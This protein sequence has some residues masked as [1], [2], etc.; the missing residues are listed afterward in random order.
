MEQPFSKFTCFKRLAPELRLKIWEDA[1]PEP[2]IIDLQLLNEHGEQLSDLRSSGWQWCYT[3]RKNNLEALSQ[4]NHEA[5]DVYLKSYQKTDILEQLG[6]FSRK[7]YIDFSRDIFYPNSRLYRSSSRALDSEVARGFLAR[8]NSA[9]TYK[10]TLLAVHPSTL[11]KIFDYGHLMGSMGLMAARGRAT[12]FLLHTFL[13]FPKLQHLRVVIDGRN[14]V[15]SG[16]HEIVEPSEANEDYVYFGC[17]AVIQAGFADFLKHLKEQN[18]EISI[19]KT[20]LALIINGKDTAKW[21]RRWDY[22]YMSCLCSRKKIE[23]V[24][25]VKKAKEVKEFRKVKEVKKVKKVVVVLDD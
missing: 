22:R 7:F 21:E 24:K 8:P 2:R 15:F 10:T 11:S 13:E 19:P 3:S 5:R 6:G 23:K 14:K 12:E 17:R 18:P 16:P 20:E 25:K 4:T 9:W 1:L